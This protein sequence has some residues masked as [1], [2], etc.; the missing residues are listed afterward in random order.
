MGCCE[1]SYNLLSSFNKLAT[2]VMTQRS[3]DHQSVRKMSMTQPAQLPIQQHVIHL[4]QLQ[5]RTN[6]YDFILILFLSWGSS[7]GPLYIEL[8]GGD[9]YSSGNVYATN[10]YGYFGPVCDDSWGTDDANV[11]CRYFMYI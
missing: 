7:P 10:R 4:Q 6:I 5:S 8:R 3:Q 9:G 11:V 1:V 2:G